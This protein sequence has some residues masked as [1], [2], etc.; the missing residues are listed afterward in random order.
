M[1]KQMML[2][3]MLLLFVG[4]ANANSFVLDDFAINEC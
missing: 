1:M 4:G 3:L 2:T